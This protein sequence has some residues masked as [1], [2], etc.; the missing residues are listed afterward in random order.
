MEVWGGGGGRGGRWSVATA[1]PWPST[2]ARHPSQGRSRPV[3]AISPPPPPPYP[4][5]TLVQSTAAFTAT[6]TWGCARHAGKQTPPRGRKPPP[7]PTYAPRR[8]A[9]RGLGGGGDETRFGCLLHRSRREGSAAPTRWRETPVTLVPPFTFRFLFERLRGGWGGGGGSWAK[10]GWGRT[11]PATV[12][13]TAHERVSSPTGS[14]CGGGGEADMGPSG[15][16]TAH[17][18]RPDAR[19][20]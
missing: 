6:S 12:A 14:G 11:V 16:L 8:V 5:R 18:R 10:A 20:R 7:A 13:S 4:A 9:E 17:A 1:T 15:L 19:A 2:R 3:S